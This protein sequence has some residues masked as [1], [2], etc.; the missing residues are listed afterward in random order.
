VFEAPD[1]LDA[2]RVQLHL[3]HPFVQRIL[4][5]F[6]AQGF[7]AQDLSR[8]T[9]VRDRQGDVVRA[10]AFGR[11]S[12]FG[13]GAVRLHDELVVVAA[14]WF[15]SGDEGHLLPDRSDED[16]RALERLETILAGTAGSRAELAVGAKV[17]RKLAETA[18]RD[19]AVLWPHVREE[20]EARAHDATLKLS[21]RGAQEAEALRKILLEQ[22][23]ALG[24]HAGEGTKQ[25]ALEIT[26]SDA[27]RL[28]REQRER[29]LE[30]MRTRLSRIDAEVATE[31]GQIQ[32]L[33]EVVLRRIEP[34]G[35]V[36]L[37]PETRG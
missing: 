8:V 12:L 36:Y 26:V 9:A 31:P 37:W 32:S 20:A 34:V 30:H 2:S 15:E 11:L 4:S 14:P 16:R 5:R 10:L 35:L 18:G 6:L 1:T 19:F 24:K 27:E 7:G 3:S 23:A 22:K 21:R 25:L 17:Q 29:D 28:E 13:G 33:Y